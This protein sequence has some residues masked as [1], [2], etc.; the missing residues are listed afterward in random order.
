MESLSC[1]KASQRVNAAL[2]TS[3]KVK[4]RTLGATDEG[5][6]LGP[7]HEDLYVVSLC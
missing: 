4:R 7:L 5:D 6:I 3:W 2:E 1:S